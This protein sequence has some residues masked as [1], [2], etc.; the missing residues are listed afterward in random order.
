MKIKRP[1]EEVLPVALGLCQ[2]MGPCCTRIALAGSIRRG[3]L[4]VG[5]IEIVCQPAGD[6]LEALLADWLRIKRIEKR[7]K[8]DGSLLAWGA[9]YKALVYTSPPAPLPQGEGGNLHSPILG[10]QEPARV[11]LRYWHGIAVILEDGETQQVLQEMLTMTPAK[12]QR[13]A[14]DEVLADT[15][16]AAYDQVYRALVRWMEEYFQEALHKIEA[17][18]HGE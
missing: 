13:M 14:Q 7:L 6:L 10:R 12:A 8:S 11:M 16:G 17:A 5:D 2:V 1:I 3:A 9:R 15:L 4:E 18:G